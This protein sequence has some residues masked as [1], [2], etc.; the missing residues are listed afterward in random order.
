MARNSHR[1]QILK[2]AWIGDAVLCLYTREK[3][4]REDGRI[5]GA[6]AERMSS[7]QF[8]SILAEPSEAEAEIGR[9]YASGGLAP[10]F[11]WIEQH[12]VPLFERQEAKR[13]KPKHVLPRR[14]EA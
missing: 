12:L 11:Q 5:D 4:L 3:I 6:K 9:V 2:D 7:N 13:E 10:A 14:T 8:L 1:E